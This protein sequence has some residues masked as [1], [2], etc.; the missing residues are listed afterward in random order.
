MM[1]ATRDVAEWASSLRYQ[2]IPS[3]VIDRAKAQMLSVLGA[4]HA[5][6]HSEGATSALEACRTWGSGDEATAF[7]SG[8]RL[9]RHSAIFANACASVS[10]DFDDY[11]FAG[12]TGHSAVCAS[13][14][15]AEE[16]GAS[17]KDVLA[18]IT[19]ANEVGARLGASFL[20]G[21]QNGQMWSYIHVLEGACVASRY[22]GLDATKTADAIGIAFTQPPYALM[23]A[24]MGPDSKILIPA[25]TT[26]EGCRA[27]DLA[28]RG[29][30]GSHVILEDRQGFL[31]RF[32]ENNLGWLLSGFGEAWMSDTMSIKVVP[33]CAYVD[34]AVDSMLEVFGTYESDNGR[35]PTAEDVESIDVKC[36]LLTSGMEGF[37]H[38]YRSPERLEPITINFSVA[39]SYGLML[40]TGDLR[41]EHLSHK[42]LDA[43]R[44]AIEAG[45]AKV[46][47][48]H[49][50]EV[51]QRG[52]VAA[53]SKGFSM[54]KVLSGKSLDGVSFE[55]YV[56]AFPAD[57]TMKTT[58]GK[59][60]KASQE[61]PVGAAGRPWEETH[62]LARRKFLTNFAGEPS[63][64]EEA[65]AAIESLEDVAD[66]REL[67]A[68]CS[69]SS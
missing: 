47:M 16:Q 50:A 33:G 3:R 13:L 49:D 36:G 53:E 8:E 28:A 43:N 21:P 54:G 52:G 68:L 23:P 41:P 58:D 62:E 31:R 38:T 57:V 7:L 44:E 48:A 34:T 12:H 5:G 10:F 35:R 39:L 37:S 67:A 64:A 63:R 60:Y 61:V 40:L 66:V 27:A 45:A 55:G 42:F 29:W 2:E 51:D 20:F 9:P 30:T 69:P 24:F 14:A 56:M 15:Y 26:V 1:G 17:G 19:V 46:S 59:I 4:I 32:N 22:C 11:V 18:S 6:R 25:S 65:A